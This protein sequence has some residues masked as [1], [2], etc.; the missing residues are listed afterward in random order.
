[1]TTI[2]CINQNR[3]RAAGNVICVEG[4]KRYFE[5]RFSPRKTSGVM[6]NY[7]TVLV[8]IAAG[9]L[10]CFWGYRMLKLTL[11]I[12]G[13][14][15]G[16]SCGWTLGLSLAPGNT[17]IALMCAVLGAA[18]GAGLCI[19]LFFVGI[20][21]LGASAGTAL[22]TALFNGLGQQPQPLVVLIVAVMFGVIAILVQKFMIVLSTAFSGSYLL[23]AG[24]LQFV[25]GGAVPLWVDPLQQPPTGVLGPG[26]LIAWIV[27]GAVGA[28]VQFR[29]G[30]RR[31]EVMRQETRPA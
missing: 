6:N 14:I 30:R 22:A 21:L 15:V 2:P 26:A 3:S 28:V 5:L 13:A 25:S 17:V 16:A 9:I 10:I 27:I 18:V 23:V 20:F 24:I 8:A 29:D 12:L 4:L 11:G 19:W 1:M 7:A 31:E